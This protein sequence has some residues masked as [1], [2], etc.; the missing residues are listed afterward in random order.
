MDHSMR[1]CVTENMNLYHCKDYQSF[2]VGNS[3]S[4][5]HL[6]HHQDR[7]YGPRLHPIVTSHQASYIRPFTLLVSVILLAAELP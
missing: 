5:T 3:R 4:T 1:T 6:Y 7:Q 2:D